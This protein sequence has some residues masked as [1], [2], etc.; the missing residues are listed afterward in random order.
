MQNGIVRKEKTSISNR[1]FIV[2]N[3]K[4]DEDL[5]INGKV[6]GNVEISNHNF[7][8]GP[9][10]R[11]QGKVHGL[12]VRIRGQMKGD[13]KATGKVEITQEAT[14]AGKIKCKRISVEEGAYFHAD[15]NL[16]WKFAEKGAF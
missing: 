10:G 3:I 2:G 14:F 1:I 12:N 7:F 9:S 4:A 8:L 16:G 11:L 6:E 13:I 5:I 15:V